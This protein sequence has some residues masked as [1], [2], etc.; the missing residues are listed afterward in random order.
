M[1][2]NLSIYL[3]VLLFLITILHIVLKGLGLTEIS[4]NLFLWSIEFTLLKNI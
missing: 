3:S 4:N 2:Y 1:E